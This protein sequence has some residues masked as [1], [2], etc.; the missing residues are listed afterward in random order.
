MHRAHFHS[1][2]RG[3]CRWRKSNGCLFQKAFEMCIG[4]RCGRHF[5]LERKIVAK[6][7]LSVMNIDVCR[8]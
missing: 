2:L 6:R 4:N 7:I 3:M 8:L 5:K 1:L